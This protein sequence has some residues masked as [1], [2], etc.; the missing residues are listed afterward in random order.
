M[1]LPILP[2]FLRHF[3]NLPLGLSKNN[4]LIFLWSSPVS[5]N[6][7]EKLHHLP[8]LFVFRAHIDDLKN[9]VVGGQLVRTDVNMDVVR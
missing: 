3:V 8:G 7:V 6:F 4:D 9:V 2:H 1:T 5:E